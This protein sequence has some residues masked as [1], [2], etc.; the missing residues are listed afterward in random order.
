MT[1]FQNLGCI[2][3]MESRPESGD[4]VSMGVTLSL[5]PVSSLFSFSGAISDDS[6]EVSWAD[7]EDEGG[8]EASIAEVGE[9][10]SIASTGSRRS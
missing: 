1:F 5:W 7:S 3:Y 9:A 4:S 2:H 6:V 10:L 8:D